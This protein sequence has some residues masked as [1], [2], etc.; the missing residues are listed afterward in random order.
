MAALSATVSADVLEL[1]L[2]RFR[3]NGGVSDYTYEGDWSSVLGKDVEGT[4]ADWT[5]TVAT[6]DLGALIT[7]MGGRSIEWISI[8]D[9][10]ENWYGFTPGAD[11]DVFRVEGLAE[12]M[13]VNYSYAGPNSYYNGFGSADFA[14]RAAVLDQRSGT[15]NSTPWWVSLGDRGTLTMTF[16]GWPTPNDSGSDDSGAD[17]SGSGGSDDAIDNGGGDTG[18][19]DNG[20]GV[21]DAPPLDL[22]TAVAIPQ[23]DDRVTDGGLLLPSWSFT[24]LELRFNEVSPTPESMFIRIGFS[25]SNSFAPPP[26]PGPGAL[27]VL[28]FA[29]RVRRRRR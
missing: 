17:D 24:G 20:G 23:F 15:D 29:L 14:E 25:A 27:G 6:V 9:T 19:D 8:T 26:V 2:G 12:G 13:S 1:D 16:D 28:G 18:G 10:G 4:D 3:F 11:I 22:F 7:A 5:R 21:I